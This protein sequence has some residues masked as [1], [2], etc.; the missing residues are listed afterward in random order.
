MNVWLVTT[1][2]YSDYQ[3]RAACSS[4]EVA[5]G[6]ADQFSDANEIEEI[7]VDEEVPVFYDWFAQLDVETGELN[8]GPW[9]S[10]AAAREIERRVILAIDNQGR[11]YTPGVIRASG[12][13]AEEALKNAAD[14]RRMLLA[15]QA[16]PADVA[17]YAD[18]I[19]RPRRVE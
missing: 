4:P 8:V 15:G 11:R 13:T 17:R 1:G 10:S 19:A 9:R 18:W 2:E 12:T 5:Q 3:V 14:Y 16:D 7:I 6:I